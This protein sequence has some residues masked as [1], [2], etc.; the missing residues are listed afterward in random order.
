MEYCKFVQDKDNLYQYGGGSS[1]AIEILGNF[2]KVDFR[3]NQS[4]KEWALADKSDSDGEYV[5]T[6]SSNCTYLEDNNGTIY[7]EDLYSQEK[8]PTRLK[9]S[10]EEFVQILDEWDQKIVKADP[11]P[12]EVIIKYEND[13][14]TIEITN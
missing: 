14:F 10:R 1:I 13:V 5:E 6:C 2:L 7:L 11:K 4:F 9:M 12:K 3:G 8:I